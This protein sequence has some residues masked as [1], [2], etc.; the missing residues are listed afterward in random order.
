MTQ[1]TLLTKEDCDGCEHARRVLAR[2]RQEFELDVHEVA[3]ESPRGK[4]LAR[5][6]TGIFPVLFLAGRPFFYGRLSERR[7]R[8]E[9]A[10]L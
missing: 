7:L 8:K 4:E 10:R 9:L 3:L 1:L 2:L 6:V 5:G